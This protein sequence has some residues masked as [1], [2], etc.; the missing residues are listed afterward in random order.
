M[1]SLWLP[2]VPFALFYHSRTRWAFLI[3]NGFSYPRIYW[4]HGGVRWDNFLK[5]L[6]QH[7][8]LLHVIIVTWYFRKKRDFC[9]SV[10][11][12][13]L[14][15]SLFNFYFYFRVIRVTNSQRG[16]WT[17]LTST[18]FLITILFLKEEFLPHLLNRYFDIV[19]MS[20]CWYF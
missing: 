3:W 9:F 11:I 20:D 16:F 10:I 5:Y 17:R 13:K 19:F 14:V 12:Q 18:P 4:C 6:L 1:I 15:S 2:L 8:H 7:A